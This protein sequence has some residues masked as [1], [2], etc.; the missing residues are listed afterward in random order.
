MVF[1]LIGLGLAPIAIRD[2]TDCV[3]PYTVKIQGNP[4]VLQ[5]SYS[6]KPFF[7]LVR[8]NYFV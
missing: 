4:T 6:F 7:G 8:Q 3:S 2:T 5:F 1:P